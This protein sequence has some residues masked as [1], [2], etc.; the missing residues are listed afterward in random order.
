MVCGFTLILDDT[1]GIVDDV[2]GDALDDLANAL[3][4]AGCDDSLCGVSCGV[5]SVGFDRE[6]ETLREAIV[7][8]IRSVTRAGYRVL[9]VEPDKRS[10]FDEI[11][12]QLASGELAAV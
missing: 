7:S 10:V 1:H 2:S 6:A 8:A 4:E 9:R 5:I 3:Y 12:A 11:N